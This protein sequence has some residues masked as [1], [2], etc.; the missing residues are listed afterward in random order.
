M[1]M[2]LKKICLRRLQIMSIKITILYV[3]PAL[4]MN[5]T[6]EM[7]MVTMTHKKVCH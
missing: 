6:M 5:I 4:L 7:R 3:I 2:V 1:R